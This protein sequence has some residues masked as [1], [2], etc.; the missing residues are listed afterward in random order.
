MRIGWPVLTPLVLLAVVSHCPAEGLKER[1]VLP[2]HEE[3]VRCLAISPDGKT[4]A[5]GSRNLDRQAG[6]A[7]GGEIKL[8][9]I[10]SGKQRAMLRG[11]SDSIDA[12]AYGPDGKTL[13]TGG[14]G[15]ITIWDLETGKERHSIQCR[16]SNPVCLAFGPDGKTLACADFDMVR[17]WDAA[18]GKEVSS[19]RCP[20]MH[21]I[22]VFSSDLKTLAV[23]HHQDANL[24]DT[25]TGK[26]RL[27][28]EDHRGQVY[29]VAFS[30]DDKTLA[31]ASCRTDY[32]RYFGEVKIWDPATG[33]AR[34]VF[35]DRINFVRSLALSPD[36]KLLA[37][38]GSK[39]LTGP[40]EVKLIEVA[41]GRD[42]AVATTPKTDWV[43]CLAFSPDGQFLAGG[44]GKE[45]RLWEVP[46][47]PAERK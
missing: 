15:A 20:V 16:D 25:T 27:F 35:K 28:L 12:L 43:M 1:A 37:L 8:W 46:P 38:A 33:C 14:R 32:P 17:I 9:D 34:A 18:T 45:L 10:E 41:T 2:A 4:V 3:G 21:S 26:E 31:V 42:L 36:G 5:T 44:T 30:A 40:S 7:S 11:H 39:E 47:A 13:A 23:P 22:P 24:Y 19:F 6:R 29:R